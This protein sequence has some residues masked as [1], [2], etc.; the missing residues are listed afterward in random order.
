MD[1]LK[2]G[3]KGPKVKQLQLTLNAWM[4]PP[5]NRLIY[6]VLPRLR[7]DGLFGPVT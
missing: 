7:D 5:Y 6:P 2:I 1:K 3:S 4:L